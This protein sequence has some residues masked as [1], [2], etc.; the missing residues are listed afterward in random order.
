[1]ISTHSI[2]LMIFSFLVSTT[3]FS[4]EKKEVIFDSTKTYIYSALFIDK[5][6]DTLTHEK[7]I[8][9]PLGI[10]WEFQK[11][12]TKY[13][14]KYFPTDSILRN[15]KSPKSKKKKQKNINIY[16]K[17]SS[18]AIEDSSSVW[19]HPFRSNQYLYTE[20]CAFPY[21][22]LTNLRVGEKWNGG[23]LFIMAGWGKF[24][25]K[26]AQTYEVV[27]QIKYD[28]NNIQIDDCW[29]IIGI[30]N[31]NKLGQSRVQ[32]IFNK[33]FG[34]LEFNYTFFDR[35]KI[36]IKLEEVIENEKNANNG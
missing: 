21:V 36:H 6:G 32:Y 28:N 30:G 10:P 3:L 17:T 19:M 11:T 4:Q 25:G 1:M 27:E 12:Q 29:K 2:R 26:V 16:K 9:Q 18:G 23:T 5:T 24:K 8:L 22:D 34:F 20:I 13:E 35:T 33:S 14:I 31:H 15:M 7:I